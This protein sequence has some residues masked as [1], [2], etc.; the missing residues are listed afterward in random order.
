MKN[1][2]WIVFLFL[3][4]TPVASA[5]DNAIKDVVS[6]SAD[7]INKGISAIKG[8]FGGNK[9]QPALKETKVAGISSI[10]PKGIEGRAMRES[11]RECTKR[12]PALIHTDVATR[13]EKI[14]H[15]AEAILGE[16]CFDIPEIE[17]VGLL[18][19]E[20]QPIFTIKISTEWEHSTDWG[21]EVVNGAVDIAVE[22]A[23]DIGFGM[24]SSFLGLKEDAPVRYSASSEAK[25]YD[26]VSVKVQ[27]VCM[28]TGR[29]ILRGEGSR[30]SSSGI[31][32]SDSDKIIE[33]FGEATTDAVRNMVESGKIAC[34]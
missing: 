26:G 27:L 23:T 25:M 14:A 2:S 19:P 20:N 24:I 7:G 22:T 10:P 15:K 28:R 1:L 6:S 21:T 13:A 18:S 3:A 17:N 32:Q 12:T 29:T 31:P 9:E 5:Q 33:F 30:K 4:I 34:G 8:L 11:V 16:Y